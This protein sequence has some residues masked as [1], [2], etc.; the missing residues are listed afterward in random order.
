MTGGAL[1]LAVLVLGVG[2]GFV[3]YALVRAEH[4][5]RERMNR[6][7]AEREARRDADDGQ[8]SRR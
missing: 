2:G 6:E 4:D 1:V 5:K 8:R 7:D 3:L